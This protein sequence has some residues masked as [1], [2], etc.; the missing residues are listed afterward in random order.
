MQLSGNLLG[1]LDVLSPSSIE[2]KFKINLITFLRAEKTN[3]FTRP[4]IALEN[5]KFTKP[6]D[7]SEQKTEQSPKSPHLIQKTVPLLQKKSSSLKI[8]VV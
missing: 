4:T 5:D 6:P 3:I 2:Y 8:E 7:E 1:L